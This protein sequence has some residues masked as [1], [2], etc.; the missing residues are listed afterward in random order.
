LLIALGLN[1]K[2]CAINDFLLRANAGSTL[3]ARKQFA[4]TVRRTRG[5][6]I[7]TPNGG[8]AFKPHREKVIKVNGEKAFKLADLTM[9][10]P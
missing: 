9:I 4:G 1:Q 10:P 3:A 5:I 7:I 2:P 8:K 6:N